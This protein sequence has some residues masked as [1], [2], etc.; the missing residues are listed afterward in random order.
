LE[1]VSWKLLSACL[2]SKILRST[3]TLYDLCELEEASGDGAIGTPGEEPTG[4]LL[5]AGAVEDAEHLGGRA[6]E[7][8]RVLAGAEDVTDGAPLRALLPV[9]HLDPFVLIPTPGHPVAPVGDPPREVGDGV[10]L[11][12]RDELVGALV[13]QQPDHRVLPGLHSQDAG[14]EALGGVPH[15]GGADAHG[16][17]GGD[18]REH[19]GGEEE[20]DGRRV[21]VERRV[22]ADAHGV[23]HHHGE[24]VGGEVDGRAR[25]P[26]HGLPDG[27]DVAYLLVPELGGDLGGAEVEVGFPRPRRP[28]PAA[29]EVAVQEVHAAAQRRVQEPLRLH[30]L[31]VQQE[32]QLLHV[33]RV[34]RQRAP[35]WRRRAAPRVLGGGRR[36]ARRRNHGGLRHHG[37]KQECARCQDQEE[38]VEG[39]GVARARHGGFVFAA[40]CWVG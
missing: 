13:Q 8:E 18:V 17:G 5:V 22:E 30:E 7:P 10:A 21:R 40:A 36:N 14:L 6:L 27:A 39:G 37:E 20:V 15:Q 29:G 35:P 16:G 9:Q 25:E 32:L 31:G 19:V 24:A 2:V 33:A 28:W 3:Q 4:D 1:L 38:A 23:V 34:H 12:R 26:A 11:V